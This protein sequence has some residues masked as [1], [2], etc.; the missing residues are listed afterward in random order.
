M[1]FSFSGLLLVAVIGLSIVI[2]IILVLT[3]GGSKRDGTD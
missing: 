1:S 3:A 2:G